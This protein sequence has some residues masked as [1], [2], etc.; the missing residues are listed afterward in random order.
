MTPNDRHLLPPAEQLQLEDDLARMWPDPW[1]DRRREKA[2]LRAQAWRTLGII[3]CLFWL[4]C[5]VAIVEAVN[6]F[7]LFDIDAAEE[8]ISP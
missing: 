8:P 5:L 7:E 6:A 4:V 2:R 1:H 3:L